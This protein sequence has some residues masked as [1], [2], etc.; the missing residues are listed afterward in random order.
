[1]KRNIFTS[2]LSTTSFFCLGQSDDKEAFQQVSAIFESVSVFFRLVKIQ[3]LPSIP[4][5]ISERFNFVYIGISQSSVT[6]K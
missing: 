2:L 3:S 1:M 4:L 5:Q 6:A